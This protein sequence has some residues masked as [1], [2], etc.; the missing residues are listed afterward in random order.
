[1]GLIDDTLVMREIVSLLRDMD[2][3][4]LERVIA[5]AEYLAGRVSAQ[6]DDKWARG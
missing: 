1:M 4:Q 2:P 3:E 5:F 6:G